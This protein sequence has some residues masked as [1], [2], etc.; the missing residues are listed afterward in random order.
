MRK[1]PR[2]DAI[3]ARPELAEHPAAY[4]LRKRAVQQALASRRASRLAAGDLEGVVEDVLEDMS[5]EAASIA[6]AVA[7]ELTRFAADDSWRVR[8][9]VGGRLDR[10]R[11]RS[12][13]HADCQ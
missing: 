3:L 2:V 9:A 8:E 7:D 5:Q 1:F 6:R 4:A 12:D 11:V 10:P 13:R